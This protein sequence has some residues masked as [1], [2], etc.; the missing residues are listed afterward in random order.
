MA[1]QPKC[2]DCQRKMDKGSLAE[3]EARMRADMQ[4]ISLANVIDAYDRKLQS[5]RE[6]QV[7]M[8][9]RYANMSKMYD[10]LCRWLNQKPHLRH[11]GI[12]KEIWDEFQRPKW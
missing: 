9:Q 1:E 3:S 7:W 6:H 11:D 12:L 2:V 8:M 5:T 10:K 4:A